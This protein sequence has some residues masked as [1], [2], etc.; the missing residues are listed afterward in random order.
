MTIT[1]PP[2]YALLQVGLQVAGR[3]TGPMTARVTGRVGRGRVSPG[4]GMVV[5]SPQ[6]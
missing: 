3:V 6:E 5:Q 4:A 2:M 1:P